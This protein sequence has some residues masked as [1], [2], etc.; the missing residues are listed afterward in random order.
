[1]QGEEKK[2][3]WMRDDDGSAAG[4]RATDSQLKLVWQYR[5][6]GYCPC[7]FEYLSPPP[8]NS[9]HNTSLCWPFIYQKAAL[10]RIKKYC[11]YNF[12]STAPPTRE[13][14]SLDKR[15]G[16]RSEVIFFYSLTQSSASGLSSS[17]RWTERTRKRWYS[18]EELPRLTR[19][20]RRDIILSS[21]IAKWNSIHF[22]WFS[23]PPHPPPYDICDS[24]SET[25][26]E[27]KKE[28]HKHSIHSTKRRNN[29]KFHR[30]RLSQ[31][32]IVSSWRSNSLY[33]KLRITN[34][35]AARCCYRFRVSSADWWDQWILSRFRN[36]SRTRQ[37]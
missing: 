27:Y 5:S 36:I 14:K 25:S 4:I 34:T 7:L 10:I 1:M 28:R 22:I 19:N 3:N 37:R 12:I 2:H 17:L 20:A 31:W 18:N 24:P 26:L 35:F 15:I 11:V 13:Y 16:K 9:T 8:E 32:L 6:T 23:A 33:Q 21:T 30:S 29:V